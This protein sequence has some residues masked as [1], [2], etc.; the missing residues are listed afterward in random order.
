MEPWTES[1]ADLLLVSVLL[2]G[3]AA[4]LVGRAVAL[5]W[6][7]VPALAGYLILLDCG[8]RF[9]HFALAKDILVAPVAFAIDLAILALIGGLGFG[10]TRTAQI[11]RQYPWLYRRTS[12]VTWTTQHRGPDA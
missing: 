4:F 9:I 8:V 1:P 2:G 5:T 11:V 7:S 10:I 12:P 3:G 6:R